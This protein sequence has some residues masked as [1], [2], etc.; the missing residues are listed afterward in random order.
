[1][2]VHNVG[3]LRKLLATTHNGM[4]QL[5][6]PRRIEFAQVHRPLD[7]VGGGRV[8]YAGTSCCQD[9]TVEKRVT[10]VLTIA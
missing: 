8:H 1:M 10:T 7:G 9:E 2:I 4:V 6:R 5:E 3:E